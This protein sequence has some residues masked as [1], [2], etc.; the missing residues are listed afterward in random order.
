MQENGEHEIDERDLLK[1]LFLFVFCCALGLITVMVFLK[2]G[3]CFGAIAMGMLTGLAFWG[4]STSSAKVRDYIAT[5]FSS[6]P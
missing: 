6:P 5:L 1:R 2:Y 3:L 4:T